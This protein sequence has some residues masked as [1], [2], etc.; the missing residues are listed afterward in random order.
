MTSRRR[1]ASSTWGEYRAG[2]GCR[3]RGALLTA[4][5]LGEGWSCDLPKRDFPPTASV[6]CRSD[7][8]ARS[9]ICFAA[10][11][12]DRIFE[13]DDLLEASFTANEDDAVFARSIDGPLLGDVAS[14]GLMEVRSETDDADLVVVY[15]RAVGFV[16]G[17]WLSGDGGSV[18]PED[19]APLARIMADRLSRLAFSAG[20]SVPPAGWPCQAMARD[21]AEH[22]PIILLALTDVCGNG[23]GNHPLDDVRRK[24][25]YDP[26]AILR[27]VSHYVTGVRISFVIV[28]RVPVPEY[29]NAPAIWSHDKAEW[30][31]I[32]LC[33]HLVVG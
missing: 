22:Q 21:K 29:L 9:L 18:S 13:P 24:R 26:P 20:C 2:G 25:G 31:T 14:W 7:D 27:V 19:V 12:A 1:T 3:H 30:P 10:P 5:D 17:V 32:N 11:D 16:A 6:A 33:H 8:P 4:D 23:R 28:D 15:F